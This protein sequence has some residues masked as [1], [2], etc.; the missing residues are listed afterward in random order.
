MV[1]RGSDELL[2]KE[3]LSR[4]LAYLIL[5]QMNLELIPPFLLSS[6]LFLFFV[7]ESSK[8][9]E[10]I[11]NSGRRVLFSIRPIYLAPL[12]E[13]HFEPQTFQSTCHIIQP[14]SPQSSYF[15]PFKD[16][17]RSSTLLQ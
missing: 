7:F 13:K 1:K 17:A 8:M 14:I 16:D 4:S 2:G 15:T 5:V 12:P 6:F 9:L 10:I 3:Y 11:L